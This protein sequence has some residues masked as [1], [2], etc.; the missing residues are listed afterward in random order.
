MLQQ[1]LTEE[2]R[3]DYAR[4]TEGAPLNGPRDWKL[5]VRKAVNTSKKSTKLAGLQK[6][7]EYMK[8]AQGM[9]EVKFTQEHVDYEV[10]DRGC[11][12]LTPD[13]HQYVLKC[14]CK[15]DQEQGSC[16]HKLAVTTQ[17]A[18]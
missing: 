12:I 14:Q 4:L 17:P 9:Y 11:P 15:K 6:L 8:Q 1:A 18:A 5:T 10:D 2:R 3:F 13:N 16:S 7:W